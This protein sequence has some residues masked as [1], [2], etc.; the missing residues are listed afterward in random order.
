M[1]GTPVANQDSA[2]LRR[3]GR[4][5]PEKIDRAQNTWFE[6]HKAAVV[7]RMSE[8]DLGP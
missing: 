6:E 3:F 5:L 8:Q 7:E 1:I 2:R 4:P